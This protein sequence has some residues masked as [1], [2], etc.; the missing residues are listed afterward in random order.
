MSVQQNETLIAYLNVLV[1]LSPVSWRQFECFYPFARSGDDLWFPPRDFAGV[2]Y[3]AISHCFVQSLF[4]SPHFVTAFSCAEIAYV[5]EVFCTLRV[6]SLVYVM[7]S[8]RRDR[9]VS[10][11]RGLGRGG[12]SRASGDRPRLRR[13]R[14][15][16]TTTYMEPN[17]KR[18]PSPQ[19]SAP[20]SDDIEALEEALLIS[21]RTAGLKR[22]RFPNVFIHWAQ[23]I[24]SSPFI[25]QTFDPVGVRTRYFWLG[26]R[27]AYSSMDKQFIFLNQINGVRGRVK[28][29][30]IYFVKKTNSLS[31]ELSEP[32]NT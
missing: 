8:S 1:W 6:G 10:A 27:T 15:A 9:S 4:I 28:P 20:P 3:V 11:T 19:R 32:P 21:I 7:S 24:S 17:L 12:N 2:A 14:T 30:T 5:L 31:I 25:C 22:G 26:K 18:P 29:H 16:G 13:P 23:W